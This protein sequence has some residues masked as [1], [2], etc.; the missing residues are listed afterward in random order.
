MS[1]KEM[2]ANEREYCEKMDF[3]YNEINEYAKHL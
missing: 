2:S 3:I 1:R